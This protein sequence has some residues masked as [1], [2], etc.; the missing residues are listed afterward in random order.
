MPKEIILLKMYD[1]RTF[2]ANDSLSFVFVKLPLLKL[3]TK[4]SQ[5][6]TYQVFHKF[7]SALVYNIFGGFSLQHLLLLYFFVTSSGNL[8]INF[9]FYFILGGVFFW[10]FINEL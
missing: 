3:S 8:C 2:E 7:C 9:F 6:Q 5:Y 10:K 4:S 1:N